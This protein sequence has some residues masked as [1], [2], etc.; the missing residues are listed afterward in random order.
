MNDEVLNK[1]KEFCTENKLEL[2]LYRKKQLVYIKKNWWNISIKLDF[3]D[4]TYS[5]TKHSGYLKRINDLLNME[6][7]FK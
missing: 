7:K 5:Q 6:F 2:R 4:M 1:L 3:S